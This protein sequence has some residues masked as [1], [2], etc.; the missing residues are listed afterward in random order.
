MSE[1]GHRSRA[2]DGGVVAPETLVGG[3]RLSV[4]GREQRIPQGGRSNGA[5]RARDGAA[6]WRE[7]LE[8]AGIGRHLWRRRC[9]PGEREGCG[10]ERWKGGEAPEVG[11]KQ[12]GGRR[13]LA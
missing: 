13:P 12:R 1:R 10:R 7:S 11:V 2:G 6:G 9:V 3:L 8:N 4:G 5:R